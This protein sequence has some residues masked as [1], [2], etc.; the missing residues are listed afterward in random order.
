MSLHT[1]AERRQLDLD[2]AKPVVEILAEA[3]LLDGLLQVA[4]RR[5]DDSDIDGAGVG[6]AQG[7]YLAVLEHAQQAHLHAGLGLADLVEEDRAAVGH[8]EEALLVLVGPGEGSPLVAEEFALE[9]RVRERPA[10]L[11]D[12][13]R[14]PPRSRVV[15]RSGDE[16]LAGSGLAGDQHRRIG[17]R[18]LLHHV[19]DALHRGARADDVLEGVLGL[20]LAAQVDVLGAES[21]VRGREIRCELHVL[22]GQAVRLERPLHVQP[23]LVRFPRLR[24]VAVDAPVVDGAH[25]LVEVRLT[26][27]HHPHGLGPDLDGALQELHAAHLG[28]DVVDDDEREF[29]A[30]QQ[31]ERRVRIGRGDDVVVVL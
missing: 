28:H 19:E 29:L 8:F 13:A 2:H 1:F 12:E 11:G 7:P 9:Q 14:F 3:P 5:R 26:R 24:D 30:F 10:V 6:G 23:E 25:Y 31:A 21:L 22:G 20:D 17:L 15:D 27:Q 18:H 16:V 4:V